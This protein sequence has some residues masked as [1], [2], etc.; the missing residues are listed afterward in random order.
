MDF[1]YSAK[2]L[3]DIEFRKIDL[4]YWH[5]SG[6]S[7]LMVNKWLQIF[8]LQNNIKVFFC[9]WM[10]YIISDYFPYVVRL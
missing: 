4:D 3:I 7:K 1:H 9:I 10:R 2:C 6:L 8:N 5:C